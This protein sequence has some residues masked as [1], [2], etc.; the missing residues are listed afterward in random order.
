MPYRITAL[1]ALAATVALAACDD[2]DDTTS[3]SQTATV[4]VVNA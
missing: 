3:P 4:Q 1:L 2:D